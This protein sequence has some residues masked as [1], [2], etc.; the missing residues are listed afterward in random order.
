MPHTTSKRRGP[1]RL[2]RRE[3]SLEVVARSLLINSAPPTASAW[4]DK[5]IN[6]IMER[7]TPS[8]QSPSSWRL[9]CLVQEL[10]LK[11]TRAHFKVIRIGHLQTLSLYL[12]VVGSVSGVKRWPNA[13]RTTMTALATAHPVD[14]IDKS[15]TTPGAPLISSGT[16]MRNV[17]QNL[18]FVAGISWI[19]SFWGNY[20]RRTA[21]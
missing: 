2:G 6:F 3:M 15:K 4:Q 9:G 20:S 21:C 18:R 13:T 19:R 10:V 16:N 14:T 12:P 11:Q 1:V 8:Y 17:K 7:V 5:H